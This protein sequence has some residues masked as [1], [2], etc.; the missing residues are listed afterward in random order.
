MNHAEVKGEVKILLEID[1]VSASR[2][3]C[4]ASKT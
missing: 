3:I 1:R 2:E 4:R